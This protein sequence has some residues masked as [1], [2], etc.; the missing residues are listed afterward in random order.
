MSEGR[1]SLIRRRRPQGW[2]AVAVLALLLSACQLRQEIRFEPDGSGTAIATVGIDEDC[3][4]IGQRPKCS[5]RAQQILGGAGPVANAE[6]GAESLPFPVRIGAFEKPS[7]GD[8]GET[9]FTLSFDFAS[10]PDLERKLAPDRSAGATQT[11]PFAFDGIMF[12]KNGEQG[13]SFATS[14]SPEAPT[15]L[16]FT[17]AVVLPGEERESNATDVRRVQGGT[18]FEWNLRDLRRPWQLH[19]STCSRDFCGPP[20]PIPVLVLIPIALAVSVGALARRRGK[21]HARLAEPAP[22]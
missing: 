17:F 5:P 20:L 2:P 10:V 15:P 9:G 22:R 13:Y 18:R 4:P 8:V 14:L 7:D 21:A 1:Q 3:P 6:A 12:G 19:A 11:S 16:V